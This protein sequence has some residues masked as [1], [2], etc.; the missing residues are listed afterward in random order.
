[1]NY[2][3]YVAFFAVSACGAFWLTPLAARLAAHLGAM[4][5]PGPRKVHARPMPRLG[6][7]AV[8]LGFLLP[9]AAMYFVHNRIS[10]EF[11]S[12]QLLFLTLAVGSA[13]MLFLGIYDDIKGADPTKKFLIQVLIALFLWAGGF[14]IA[15]V[16]NPWGSPIYLSWLQ[17]PVTVLWLVGVTN[18][19]NLLD[20]IDGLVSGVTACIG[21][22][23]AVI[24]A[25]EGHVVIALLTVALA[26][27][28][29]GFLGHNYSPA[30][31]FLGDS[32]S[33]AIGS[34]LGCI[35]VFSLFQ[36]GGGVAN[37]MLTVPLILFALP[38]FDTSR[39][40]YKRWR[41]GVSIFK[42]DRN[43]I[44][45]RLL[46]MGLNHRQAAW[47]LYLVAAATG[48]FAVVLSLFSADSQMKFSVLFAVLAF[49]FF[50]IWK[51]RL[52]DRLER[53]TSPT[54]EPAPTPAAQPPDRHGGVA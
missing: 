33:L 29:F 11:H 22:A 46:A 2:K 30:R 3:T 1:M 44:H 14:R 6:G 51:V 45:H 54:A 23:L 9:W 27:A 32:G 5:I 37:P 47:V 19:I 52:R 48:G 4:D 8:Y 17:V 15:W 28:C 38:I 40:M 25:L 13:A 53:L 42:A 10:T 18:A 24:S 12:Y 21:L 16:Q 31:I 34:I 50:V 41:K 39:V 20:G 35:G 26:G 7:V 43:H 36:G 49:G